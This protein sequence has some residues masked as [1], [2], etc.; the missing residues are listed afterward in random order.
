[1]S[2]SEPQKDRLEIG[3]LNEIE[4]L[5]LKIRSLEDEKRA[6]LRVLAKVRTRGTAAR[7][8]S[9]R[10]SVDRAAAEAKILEVLSDGKPLTSADLQKHVAAV[11]FRM[12]DNTFR[13]HL[14]RMKSK[15]LIVNHQGKRGLW[16]L[17]VSPSAF[18]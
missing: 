12:N 9:R 18:G 2:V 17:P 13:S 4:E 14:H 6:L 1:M 8:V 3:I 16:S 11:L 7:T 10:N 5:N 15:G